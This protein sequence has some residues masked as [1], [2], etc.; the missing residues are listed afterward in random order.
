MANVFTGYEE[1]VELRS[2][3]WAVQ[4]MKTGAIE[5]PE[6]ADEDAAYEWMD[7]QMLLPH[8]N[9]PTN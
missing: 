5:S 7:E 8:Q 9:K 2:G 4:N 1:I 3:K 6:F